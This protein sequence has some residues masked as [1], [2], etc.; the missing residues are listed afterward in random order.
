MRRRVVSRGIAWCRVMG[1]NLKVS[2]STGY[3]QGSDYFPMVFHHASN[4]A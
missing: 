3:A 4:D 2:A 1:I